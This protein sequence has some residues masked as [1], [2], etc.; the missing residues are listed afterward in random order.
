LE[1]IW[2]TP[3][4]VDEHCRDGVPSV[5]TARASGRWKIV[6]RHC[7]WPI[8]PELIGEVLGRS[9]PIQRFGR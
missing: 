9:R 8:D 7:S 5:A 4:E 6:V 3:S 1:A 2:N